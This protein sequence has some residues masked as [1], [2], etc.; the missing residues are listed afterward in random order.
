M[1]HHLQAPHTDTQLLFVATV[2]FALR[3]FWRRR[4][5]VAASMNATVATTVAVIVTTTVAETKQFTV[6]VL[7]LIFVMSQSLMSVYLQGDQKTGLF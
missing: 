6:I 5:F 2:F 7:H 4:V 3:V 1:S